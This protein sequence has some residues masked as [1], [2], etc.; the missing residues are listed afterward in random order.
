MVDDISWYALARDIKDM[1]EQEIAERLQHERVGQRRKGVMIRL[2]QRLVTL[3]AK[4]E[5]EEM[6][7]EG[8]L[9]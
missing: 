4:R 1:C 5:R 6:L 9:N 7:A 2:H 8:P 3:R